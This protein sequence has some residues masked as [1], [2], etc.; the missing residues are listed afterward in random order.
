MLLPGPFKNCLEVRDGPSE[1]QTFGSHSSV[2]HFQTAA[3]LVSH[4]LC[5][6]LCRTSSPLS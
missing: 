5:L 6:R 2:F 4:T 1:S 3:G